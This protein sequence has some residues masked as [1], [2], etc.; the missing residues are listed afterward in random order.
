MLETE[1]M[2][3]HSDLV[4]VAM[5]AATQREVVR[6]PDDSVEVA[7]Y[8]DSDILWW[9]SHAVNSTHFGRMALLL[10]EWERM[11]DEAHARMPTERANLLA[12]QIKAIG[13]TYR[14]SIDAKSSESR[15][16]DRNSQATFFDRVARR[17]TEHVYTAQDRQSAGLRGAFMGRRQEMDMDRAD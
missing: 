4:E 9:W 3:R 17:R 8:V 15:R 16:D 12:G 11:A 10:T 13:K 7:E 6:Q 1:V 5:Q 14:R 2:D